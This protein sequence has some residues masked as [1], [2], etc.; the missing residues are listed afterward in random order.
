M[1]AF[2]NSLTRLLFILGSVFFTYVNPQLNPR[3]HGKDTHD[4]SKVLTIDSTNWFVEVIEASY[5]REVLLYF[6]K[7]ECKRCQREQKT[8]ALMAKHTE[9]SP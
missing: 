5:W 2:Q 9:G 7:H 1:V 8:L 6:E 3:A 4:P